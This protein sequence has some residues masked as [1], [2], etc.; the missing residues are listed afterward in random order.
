M[1]GR[2]RSR[3]TWRGEFELTQKTGVEILMLE[4]D[5]PAQNGGLW[6]EDVIVGFERETGGWRGRFATSAHAPTCRATG[7]GDR[8]SRGAAGRE[9]GRF[10]R[11]TRSPVRG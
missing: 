11:N 1:C 3:R 8:S 4:E 5:G 2:C 6:I 10:R 9:N 7:L